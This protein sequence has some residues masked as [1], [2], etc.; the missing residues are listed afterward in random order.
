MPENPVRILFYGGCHAAAMRRIVDQYA[1]NV[2]KA[3]HLTNF[4]L[5]R[6]KRPFPY[7]QL[8][9][10]DLVIFNP[11]LNKHDH[12]TS[13]LEDYC[14]A[15]GI[16]MVKYPWLQWEGYYPTIRK[17][18]PGW[19]SGWWMTGLDEIADESQSFQDFAGD[20]F[21]GTALHDQALDNLERTSGFLARLEATTDVKILAHVQDNFRSTRL[22]LTPDHASSELYKYILAEISRLCGLRLDPAFYHTGQEIQAGIQIPVLPS[23][24]RALDLRFPGGGDFQNSLVMGS[25]TLSLT[26]Y[27]K[28]HY[29]RRQVCFATAAGNTRLRDPETG[30]AHAIKEGTEILGIASTDR[31]SQGYQKVEVLRSLRGETRRRFPL[32]L[33]RDLNF[34]ARH[35]QM[36]A[37]A[38]VASDPDERNALSHTAIVDRMVI[39]AQ[40]AEGG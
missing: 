20:V 19:Y 3:E 21:E 31:I 17:I 32:P 7:D 37:E 38:V 23:V 16:G 27:L 39:P 5:I 36:R 18:G 29:W 34:F 15:Q 26:E 11:I 2:K 14:R 22:F 33:G 9:N 28:L 35:W 6:E 24:A 30:E 4:V 8:K 40:T 1:V 12:N 25:S 13:H 10:F